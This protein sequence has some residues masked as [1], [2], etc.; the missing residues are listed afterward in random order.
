[1]QD[2]QITGIL[3]HTTIENVRLLETLIGKRAGQVSR[4]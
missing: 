2:R 1:M 3:C 4:A